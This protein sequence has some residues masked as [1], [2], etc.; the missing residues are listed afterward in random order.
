MSMHLS[1][2]AGSTSRPLNAGPARLPFLNLIFRLSSLARSRRALSALTAEQLSDVGLSRD[3]AD[4]EA[5]RAP[6]DAPRYWLGP[7]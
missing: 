6:W 2:A 5:N 1:S 7:R 4:H 3:A